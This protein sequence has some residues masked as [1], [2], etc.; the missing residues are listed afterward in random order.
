MIDLAIRTDEEVEHMSI[1]CGGTD[2]RVLWVG[3]DG[4]AVADWHVG[5]GPG[6]SGPDL[7]SAGADVISTAL[8]ELSVWVIGSFRS[9]TTAGV[10]LAEAIRMPGIPVA[11]QMT[12]VAGLAGTHV[13]IVRNA[14]GTWLRGN[15]T[16]S[17][18]LSW[19]RIGTEIVVSNRAD[20]LARRVS[21]SI[22]PLGLAVQLLEPVCHPFNAIP[23]W[24]KVATLTPGDMLHV[25][26]L[27]EVRSERWWWAP[28]TKVPLD[29]GGEE[30]RD[31]ITHAVS[32]L[33]PSGSVV[34]SDLSGGLDSTSVTAL[35]INDRCVRR[36]IGLT[37][38]GD[39]A[40]E[41]EEWA[42]LAA[43][44]M[45][46]KNHET[47]QLRGLPSV[48]SGMEGVSVLTELPTTAIANHKTAEK[49]A[50]LA[51]SLNVDRHV[52]GHG[53]DHLF[54]GHPTL[55]ADTFKAHPMA[56]LSRLR[57]YAGILDWPWWAALRE[58]TNGGRFNVWL[59]ASAL[60][61][62]RVTMRDPLLGWGLPLR[63]PA[64]IDTDILGELRAWAATCDEPPLAPQRGAHAE[65]DTIR[66][67]AVLARGISQIS[68]WYG[69][70]QLSPFFDDRVLNAVMGIETLDRVNPWEY[71]PLVKRAL[72]GR[73][74]AVTLTRNTKD[75]GSRDVETGLRA[76]HDAVRDLL[77]DS[78]MCDYGL[79]DRKKLAAALSSP[80]H[81]DLEDGAVL[82]TVAGETWLRTQSEG[83]STRYGAAYV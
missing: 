83:A 31:A 36:T 2:I 69:C 5:A 11:E 70:P 77:S 75:E 16:G 49:I 1:G 39:D 4:V 42:R 56:T 30:L 7:T 41:D 21:A 71:K 78:M 25:S 40:G 3:G 60:T 9:V 23:L 8:P 34:L 73:A 55:L 37:I 48:L 61:G 53:G 74:P 24:N 66:Q 51:K 14:E 18:V 12:R 6:D 52:T 35:L 64:W 54:Y 26:R 79:I 27:G 15:A 17:V 19:G 76:N 80:S 28:D 59:S 38:A 43:A 32:D 13:V 22:N 46:L 62:S 82:T 44:E 58:L 67:G 10:R 45:G 65:L 50:D 47:L 20:A 68:G 57:A 29:E 63:I 72:R 33:A 81:P